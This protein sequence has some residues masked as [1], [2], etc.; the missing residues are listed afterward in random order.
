MKKCLVVVSLS[1]AVTAN[2]FATQTKP[3]KLEQLVLM[4]GMVVQNSYL[5]YHDIY[6]YTKPGMTEYGAEELNPIAASLF[7]N[8]QWDLGYTLAVASQ[9][10]GNGLAYHIDPTGNLNW[11]V[12][13]SIACA[14]ILAISTWDDDGLPKMDFR[15]TA[16]VVKF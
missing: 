8:G 10:V 14:E 2:V 11:V 9:M 3:E 5:V 15:V 4:T 1:L 6:K 13:A 16:L 7:D 12:N